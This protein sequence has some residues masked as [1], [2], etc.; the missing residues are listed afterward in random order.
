[1][2]GKIFLVGPMGAGKSTVGRALAAKLDCEFFDTDN[3]I[4]D[5]AGADISWIFDV[6][7]ELGFRDREQAVLEELAAYPQDAVVATGGGIVLREEN[8]SCLS[9]LDCVVYL[10]ATVDQLTKRTAKDKKR[11]LLQVANPRAKITELIEQRDPLYRE[12]ASF[13]VET[14][15]KN[16]KSVVQKILKVIPDSYI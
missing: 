14:G 11:P 5:R 15:G 16:P 9:S 12:V 4:E 13:V 3:V 10:S 8:R 2:A 6:E 1:M 7:G